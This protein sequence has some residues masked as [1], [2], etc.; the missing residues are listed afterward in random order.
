MSVSLA[1]AAG[2]TAPAAAEGRLSVLLVAYQCGPGMGSVSQIGW[3]W[4][5]GL[6][7]RHDVTLVTH[8]RN[9]AAIEAAG[10][11]AASVIYV[12]TEWF[13]GPLYRLSRRLFPRS[14]HAVFTLSQLDWFVFDAQAVRLLRQ[15]LREGAPWQ[16]VHVATP[17][18]TVAPTRLHA[19]GLPVVR[20]PLNC[21]LGVPAG[22]A[23]E[24]KADSM[25]LARLRLLPRLLEAGLGSLRRSAAVLVATAATREAVPAAARGRCIPMLENAVDLARFTAAPALP[26]AGPGQPLR[27]CFVG[28]LVAVK[29]LPLLL[30]AM[31]SV[32]AQGLDVRLEVA[33]DGPMGPAWR[34]EASALGLDDA[35]AWL[36]ALDGA[37]VAALMRRSHALCLPSV[38]ES[39]GAVL[40]EAMACARPVIAVDYG[41]PAEVVDDE[42]G[43]KVPAT[44]PRAAVAGLE[45][46]LRDLFAHPAAW[47]AR[48][49]AA[50][51]RVEQV[52]TWPAR[53][54]AAERLYRQVLGRARQAA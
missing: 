34:A 9:R 17:V 24:M 2:L 27:L 4:F 7:R 13:A 36:G 41:G 26:P 31:A 49:Q 52:H 44:G 8:A 50:R 6:A 22:F 51:R 16:L 29:A 39:G 38:R 28:R 19:L 18:T 30:R 33:G 45:S 25:S 5:R 10:Q 3:E 54:E 11:P 53:I 15:R 43:R 40:L 48:G 32:R 1:C 46:A 47:A 37:A 14:E 21:G 20:G 35:V 23:A 42:V 12:D